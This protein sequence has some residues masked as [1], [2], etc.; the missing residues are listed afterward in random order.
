MICVTVAGAGWFL[1]RWGEAGFGSDTQE[2][3]GRLSSWIREGQS[4]HL[5]QGRSISHCIIELMFPIWTIWV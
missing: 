5:S 4:V 2:E 1:Q 3:A